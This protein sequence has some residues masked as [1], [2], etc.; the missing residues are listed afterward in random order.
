MSVLKLLLFSGFQ[1]CLTCWVGITKWL[2]SLIFVAF[3]VA[4]KSKLHWFVNMKP[5]MASLYHSL[6]HLYVLWDE[7]HTLRPI[8]FIPSAA[9]VCLL[10]LS[11]SF[12]GVG[13]ELISFCLLLSL[14]ASGQACFTSSASRRLSPMPCLFGDVEFS[15]KPNELKTNHRHKHTSCFHFQLKQVLKEEKVT[16]RR[17]WPW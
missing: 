12:S 13:N 3:E 15:W 4:L 16:Q 2:Q 8:S 9:P 14:P 6:I 17:K 5:E 10:S 1:P 11:L 7:A